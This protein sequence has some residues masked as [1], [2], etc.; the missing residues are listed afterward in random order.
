M[1]QGFLALIRREIEHR[2][3]G[4]PAGIR[5]KMNQLQD[6]AVI[7]ALYE[8]SAAGVPI[9]LIV[10]GLCCLRPGVPGLSD[11][12]RVVSVLGRFLEHSRIYC[13]EN[14]GSPELFTGSADW[15]ERNLDR[16]VE[17]IAPVRDPALCR[18]LVEILDV[19]ERDNATAWDGLPDGTYVRRRPAEG[20]PARESQ[21]EFI[22]RTDAQAAHAT[23]ARPPAL[24]GARDGSAR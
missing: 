13:F 10:R 5:A 1:R 11:S 22:R 23:A 4:R 3:A 2:R 24:R 14:G 19:Y 18:E 6:P 8:A 16:R 9:A 7:R 17:T 20:E 15:M 21:A 12:I